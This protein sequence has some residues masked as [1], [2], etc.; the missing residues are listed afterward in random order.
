MLHLQR[1]FLVSVAACVWLLGAERKPFSLGA[2]ER[3]AELPADPGRVISVGYLEDG[4]RWAITAED[5]AQRIPRLYLSRPGGTQAVPVSL[6]ETVGALGAECQFM[7]WLSVDSQGHAW[8]PAACKRGQELSFALIRAS[9]DG[10]VTPVTLN[11][12]VEARSVAVGTDGMLFVLG[13]EA[14]FFR[15]R[16]PECHLIHQYTPSGERIRSFSPCP[17]GEA[18]GFGPTSRRSVNYESL[19]LEADYGKVWRQHDHVLHLLPQTGE[20]R[21]FSRDGVLVRTVRFERPEGS[22][23]A[24]YVIHALF[25]LRDGRFL[26]FWRSSLREENTVRA[27]GGAALHGRDGRM[28][29]NLA[30]GEPFAG[31]FPAF[32]NARGECVF[33]SIEAATGRTTLWKAEV[34]PME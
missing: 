13:I 31:R 22:A 4:S 1:V 12:P 29:S 15:G 9:A 3:I 26:A 28:L 2:P 30:G 14:A 16:A 24:P 7:P 17:A 20:L 8:L 21:T 27:S 18:G 25:P 10:L 23:D 34:L 11:P 19:K 32:V 5:V 6:A 33:Q